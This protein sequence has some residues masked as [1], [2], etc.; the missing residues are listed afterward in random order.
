M[1][2][3]DTERAA[4]VVLR[5]QLAVDQNR[6]EFVKMIGKIRAAGVRVTFDLVP[7]CL[8]FTLDR[9]KIGRIE[10]I[11]GLGRALDVEYKNRICG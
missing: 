7:A 9:V 4:R 5:R 1:L 6:V 2:E 3:A 11:L 10:D 8:E